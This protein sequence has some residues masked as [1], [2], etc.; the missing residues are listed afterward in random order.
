MNKLLE[1]GNRYAKK[2]D[3]KDFALLKVCLCAMGILIGVSIPK[4]KMRLA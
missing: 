1:L 4:K 2:S 3:W